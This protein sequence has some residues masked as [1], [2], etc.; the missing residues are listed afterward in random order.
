MGGKYKHVGKCKEIADIAADMLREGKPLEEVR[1]AVVTRLILCVLHQL[2]TKPLEDFLG[3]GP[4]LF[5]YH[6]K[7]CV[8]SYLCVYSNICK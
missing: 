1:S 8:I 6:I 4:I 3:C 2:I 5:V 7:Y